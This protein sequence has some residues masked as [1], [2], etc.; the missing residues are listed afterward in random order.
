MPIVSKM[1][2][3]DQAIK[4]I[5]R[6]IQKT[7]D[8]RMESVIRDYLEAQIENQV[9]ANKKAMPKKAPKTI[10][11]YQKHGYNTEKFLVRTGESTKLKF[12]K[13]GNKITIEPA[14]PNILKN[15]IPSRVDW[16]TLND[17]AIAKITNQF[18]EQLKK[19]FK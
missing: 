19:E 4:E 17:E 5:Q 2:G 10:E 11:E 1:T 3:F 16:M 12:K 15:L 8:T 18:L 9:D 7:F 13:S 14:G 6:N